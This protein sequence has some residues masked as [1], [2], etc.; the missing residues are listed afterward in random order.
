VAG[1]SSLPFCCHSA[2]NRKKQGIKKEGEIVLSSVRMTLQ[3]IL[4][5]Y[6]LVY[7]L[8]NPNP[9][10]TAAIIILMEAF[11]IYTV[12]AKFKGRL[13]GKL[14]KIIALSMGLEQEPACCILS[15]R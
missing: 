14:K 7:V 10:I 13:N 8:D 12:M 2:F 5:G 9:F 11:A 3:L 1:R 15:L 6:V 4:A